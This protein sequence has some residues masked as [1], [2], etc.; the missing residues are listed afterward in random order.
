MLDE[1]FAFLHDLLFCKTHCLIDKAC[2]CFTL[3]CENHL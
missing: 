3:C 2:S 1:A